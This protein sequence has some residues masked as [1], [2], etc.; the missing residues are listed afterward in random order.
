VSV[1]DIEGSVGIVIPS[2]N[3][4]DL[5]GD[6]LRSLGRQTAGLADVAAVYLADDCSTDA[7]V[8]VAVEAWSGQPPLTV[9]R[10]ARN[11]GTYANANRALTDL[12]AVHEW[13][14]VLHDDD[15]ARPE[16]LGS[17]LHRLRTCDATVATICSSWNLLHA[18]GSIEPG[19]QRRS[20]Q[21]EIVK[22]TSAT[23]RGTLLRGCWWHFSGSAIRTS[24]LGAIGPFDP[25]L[26]QCADWDWLIRCLQARWDV[27]Y[28]P[29]SLIDYRQHTGTVS[30]R[31]FRGHRDLRE[32][33]LLVSRYRSFLERGDVLGLHARV[34]EALARRCVS[35]LLTG[36]PAVAAHAVA[37]A[38]AVVSSLVR[39]PGRQG[40]DSSR[41]PA[42]EPHE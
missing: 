34:A 16:W 38:P 15:L 23:V 42:S 14:L 25:M 39:R 31:S 3:R 2:Y 18:D 33:L 9:R 4:A 6:T 22:G 7:T 1:K 40:S 29:E 8:A 13:L 37:F 19:E 32:Q 41:T 5:I 20:R 11:V 30:S 17:M 24:A 21:D 10:G 27:L 28:V 35:A 26:P 12:A 36:R